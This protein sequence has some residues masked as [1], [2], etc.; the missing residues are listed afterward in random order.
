MPSL[1]KWL[2]LQ[3]RTV[4][5]VWPQEYSKATQRGTV[6]KVRSLQ[7]PILPQGE[8][9]NPYPTCPA[10]S[11]APVRP[12]SVSPA[13][14][15]PVRLHMPPG[16]PLP[17]RTPC[18]PDAPTLHHKGSCYYHAGGSAGST[19]PDRS[20]TDPL[21]VARKPGLWITTGPPHTLR[22]PSLLHF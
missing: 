9:V 14:P 6:P 18:P 22:G 1:G 17:L 13:S 12:R 11:P 8:S 16:T 21:P 19:S 5:P 7:R 15:P 20:W 3:K 2:H 4:A 10:H